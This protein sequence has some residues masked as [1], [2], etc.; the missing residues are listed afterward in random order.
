MERWIMFM[1]S[2]GGLVFVSASMGLLLMLNHDY[3][4]ARYPGSTRIGGGRPKFTSLYK[5][6]VSQDGAYRTTADSLTVWRWY[7]DRFNLD[8]FGVVNAM[9]NCISLA[10]AEYRILTRHLIGVT[11]CSRPSGTV[12]FINRTVSLRPLIR[13]LKLPSF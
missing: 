13:L 8:P 4:P 10:K 12:I 5:G 9:E 7:A 11:I 2:T 3:D 1:L 6:Y